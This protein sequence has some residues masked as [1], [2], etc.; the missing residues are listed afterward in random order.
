MKIFTKQ[1]LQWYGVN[2]RDLPWRASKDP[3]KIWLSEIILQQT[4]VAQGLPYYRKFVEA[5]PTVN[6]LAE[7]PVD[8]VLR[9]WQGL[10]YYSRA[11]NLHACAK[12]IVDEY[13]GNFPDSA[14]ELLKLKGVGP[15]T[16]SAIASMA[17]NEVVPVVD[18]N[19]YRVLSRYDDDSTDISGGTAYSHFYSRAQ[20][21]ISSNHPGEFNQA[22]MEFGATHCTPKA[23]LC[24]D[25]IFQLD[26]KAYQNNTVLDRPVKLKKVKVTNRTFHYIVF[27]HDDQILVRQ[28]K[29]K[30][31][32]QG[33][34]DFHCIEGEYQV[35][36]LLSQLNSE[37]GDKSMAKYVLENQSIDIKHVLTHQRITARFYH[38][39]AGSAEVLNE[40]CEKLS[41]ISVDHQGLNDLA[42]PILIEN[43]LKNSALSLF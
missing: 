31:I 37:V 3:Y 27:E 35:E 2:K 32:W 15:Y 4:R 29:G 23:P 34:H 12:Q 1:I 17:F 26:C 11:R 8:T 41:L 24:A 13:G 21:L 28:R 33:L 36:E 10:G 38:F 39:R 42:K 43:Y 14:Q 30:D 9:L 20:E 16:A 40:T 19:V 25:C 18:G 7:A 5:F 6:D 22:M